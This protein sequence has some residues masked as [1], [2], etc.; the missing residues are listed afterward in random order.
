MRTS[1]TNIGLWMLSA[2]A[3]HDFGYLTVDQVIEKLIQTM[4]TIGKLERYEGHLLNW[5]DI[6]TLAPLL[7][8]YISSVDSGNLLGALWTLQHGLDEL[9]QQPV[10]D[11][12]TLEGLRDTLEILKQTLQKGDVPGLK[13]RLLNE[14]IFSWESRQKGSLT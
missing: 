7:P 5:Y 4:Q 1:P 13:S 6:E 14:Q 3:A 12:S 2:L 9:S 11:E 10:L 8:R